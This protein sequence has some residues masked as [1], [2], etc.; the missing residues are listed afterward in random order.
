MMSVDEWD[1]HCHKL[2]EEEFKALAY[3]AH[4]CINQQ[5]LANILGVEYNPEHISLRLND[6]L[7]VAHL[8]GKGRLHPYSDELPSDM[9][10]EF[11]CYQVMETSTPLIR[12]EVL[13]G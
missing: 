11:Y 4:S 13:E 7:L 1:L 9:L 10:L 2:T 6:V 12:D 8:K 5:N 3:D